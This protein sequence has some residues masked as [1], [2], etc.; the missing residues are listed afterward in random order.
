ML[1]PPSRMCR[2]TATRRT[3]NRALSFGA[4][5]IAMSERSVV[6]PPTSQTRTVRS[7]PALAARRARGSRRRRASRRR[8]R[9]AAPR[10]A[11]GEA[12]RA[13]A[14]R[15]VSSRATSSNDAGTVS[16]TSCSASGASGCAA[17]HARATCARRRALASTGESLRRRPPRRRPTEG[18][19]AVRSTAAWREPA[20]RRR[21]EAARDLGAAPPRELARRPTSGSPSTS[22]GERRVEAR[23]QERTRLASR[24]SV[25]SCGTSKMRRLGR[26]LRPARID[27]RVGDDRVR[28]AEIDPDDEARV[29]RRAH[30]S[31]W[32]RRSS[33]TFQRSSCFCGCER[34]GLEEERADLGDARRGAS[35]GTTSPVARP[36]A[37]SVD[38][39]RREL[40]ELALLPALERGAARVLAAHASSRRS[41]SAPARRRRRRARR[42]RR[43]RS[44]PSSMPNGATQSA[45]IGGST[46]GH[47]GHGAL[48]ADVV[49][50]RR[51]AAD[52]DAAA[53]PREAVVRGAARDGEIEIGA[54]E[55][56]RRRRAVSPS[57]PSST[58]D[59]AL[60]EQRA[61]HHAAVEEDR[62]SGGA[63]SSR[64]FVA[65]PPGR[66]SAWRARNAARCF[67][68]AGVLRVRQAEL[69]ER[70]R[71]R[72]RPAARRR[73]RRGKKPSTSARSTSSRVSSVRS[74]PP[75]SFEPRPGD[76]D[77][78]ALRACC[79]RAA[80]P[81]R[82]AR[83]ARARCSCQRSS[84]CA[85]ARV[86]LLRDD[87]REREVHVVAA[88]QDVIADGD[89]LER[90]L[91]APRRPR[92]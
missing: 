41:G 73:R 15:S 20:L 28:R 67:V 78:R 8:T 65:R 59:D 29:A 58:L 24:A 66:A 68:T 12:R 38:L 18:S 53:A 13:R 44:V 43:R 89:A 82:R 35:P 79:R 1:S 74:V 10:A 86:E 77:R 75:M 84:S 40:L 51:A 47:R 16:T 11:S 32:P 85:L 48:D 21:D 91:A 31:L 63:A 81:S 50:A 45:V 46:P 70:R 27:R 36:S 69:R 61:L 22:P 87:V 23:R 39:D 57:Q 25:V 56:A 62:A 9:P 52:A 49:R 37:G 55:H 42:R 64:R 72:A 7:S 17:S 3:A 34:D 76:R 54:R 60:A 5:A 92:R 80:A 90:E 14:A 30:A 19:R 6:P 83:R 4:Y 88:E 26:G 2:P 33:S 71:A